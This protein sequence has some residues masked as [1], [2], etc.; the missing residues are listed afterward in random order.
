MGQGAIEWPGDLA[1][2]G[3]ADLHALIARAAAAL[4]FRY[5]CYGIITRW[6][7]TRRIVSIHHSYPGPWMRRYLQ[8]RY[9]EIDPVVC[10]A[11]AG[12]CVI[13]WSDALFAEVPQLWAEARQAGLRHGVSLAAWDRGGALGIFSLARDEGPLGEQEQQQVVPSAGHLLARCHPLL[14]AHLARRHGTVRHRSLTVRERE[15]LLWS[16]DGKTAGEIGMI[17]GISERTVNFHIRHVIAKFDACNKTQAIL[18][19]VAA[20]A[21]PPW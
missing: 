18:S 15:V 1:G 10:R 17:L 20:G 4:G 16:A 19:A 7:L 2:R 12:E 21:I 5:H 6:P 9:L 8:K 11:L 14:V 3:E 13:P